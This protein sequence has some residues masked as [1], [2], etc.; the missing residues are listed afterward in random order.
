MCYPQDT[1]GH[2][3]SSRQMYFLNCSRSFTMALNFGCWCAVLQIT[4]FQIIVT[5]NSLRCMCGFYCPNV[6]TIKSPSSIWSFN[7]FLQMQSYT[8]HIPQDHK[9][10]WWR[11][12]PNDIS[13]KTSASIKTSVCLFVGI[14]TC[15][16]KWKTNPPT[17]VEWKK[18]YYQ[19]LQKTNQN[20][21]TAPFMGMISEFSNSHPV[22]YSSI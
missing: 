1:D 13:N 15:F 6:K 21:S 18:C 14:K 3:H 4:S 12:F 5:I 9:H 17:D 11:S 22:Q 8:W 2:S 10:K 19:R 20:I 16:N 7:I